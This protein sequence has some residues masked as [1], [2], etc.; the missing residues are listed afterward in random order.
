VWQAALD[1]VAQQATDEEQARFDL[2]L[3][4]PASTVTEVQT[5]LPVDPMRR[6][7][8]LA[9][10]LTATVLPAIKL[11]DLNRIVAALD[12]ARRFFDGPVVDYLRR[13]LDVCAE[14]D[15]VRGPRATLPV[16]L[17]I[18]GLI[19]GSVRQVKPNVQRELLTVG[20]R[21]A[22]FAG[23]LYR[24]IGALDW[25]DYWR[26]RAMEWAQAAGDLPMQG[27]ILLKK[28]QSAW[29]TRDAVRMLA[30]ARAVQE[31]PWKVPNKVRAEAAQ[32]EARG[33]AMLGADL[34]VVERK[35]DEAGRIFAD[36]S[37]AEEPGMPYAAP[38]LGVQTAICYQEAGRPH[39][40]IE[41]YDDQLSAHAFSR[42]DYGYFL[43]LKGAAF[44]AA[45]A[46][47]QAADAGL[48]ALAVA[49]A[50]DS[51]RTMRELDRL[52]ARLRP[53]A[54][55]QS[56]RELCEAVRAM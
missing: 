4:S 25:A 12:D 15:G 26:D 22:E 24:D 31:G 16:V 47:D 13:Q 19:E 2:L 51:V 29:D 36:D 42:R 21:G 43:S 41:Y 34:I 48:R 37:G 33:Q 5:T 17:A 53:W 11:D 18:I 9:N 20:A 32:Q 56:V 3:S 6:R 10:G 46:P 44:A 50:T 30:L 8:L 1:T 45:R 40:A 27:Y 49:A 55:R 39:R 52:A 23:W 28:S 38:L 35:L 54:G 7:T 14:E